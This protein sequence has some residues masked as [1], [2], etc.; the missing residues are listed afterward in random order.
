MPRRSITLS[1][2]G[3]AEDVTSTKHRFR[4][5]EI[6]FGKIRPYFHKVGIA[7]VDG[8]ASSDAI[9]I[10]PVSQEL[11]GLVLLAV[12]SDPFVAQA[13]QTMREGSKMPR[14]DWKLMK[15]YAIPFPPAGLL[16]SFN[17]FVESVTEQLKTLTFQTQKLR[18]AR[19]L[20]LPRL[21]SGEII[22]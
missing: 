13:S 10:R 22:V 2:W 3:R 5:G 14:A 18:A 12:S 16:N 9:V 19:D 20:L 7:F 6:L 17:G 21:M 4:T 1:E 8:V 15:Q 11:R